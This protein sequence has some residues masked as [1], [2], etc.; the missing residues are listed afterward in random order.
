[1]AKPVFDMG[2]LLLVVGLIMVI[3]LFAS[4]M[5]VQLVKRML[6][7]PLYA[8]ESPSG[9]EWTSADH[10]TYYNSE[11]PDLQTGQWARAEWPGIRAGQG[12]SHTHHWRSGSR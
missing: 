2:P 4:L 11:R 6:G 10:L 1:M 5:L 8:D 3:S 12:L 7:I 9:P